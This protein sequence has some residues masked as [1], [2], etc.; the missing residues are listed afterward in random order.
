MRASDPTT[1][2]PVVRQMP[3]P[4]LPPPPAMRPSTPDAMPMVPPPAPSQPSHPSGGA[5]PAAAWFQQPPE[6]PRRVEHEARAVLDGVAGASNAA[7][8]P[9]PDGGPVRRAVRSSIDRPRVTSNDV[10]DLVWFEEDL[11]SRIRRYDPWSDA[12]R[13]DVRMDDWITAEEPTEKQKAELRRFV[14]RALGRVPTTEPALLNRLLAESVDEEGVIDRPLVVAAG[15]LSLQLDPIEVLKSS[16]EIAS[17]LGTSDKLKEAIDASKDIAKA[18]RVSTPLVES[19][20]ARLRKE[21]V[22]ANRSLPNDYL[23]STVQRTMLEER[24][25]QRREVL[26]QAHL[27]GMLAAPGGSTATYLPDH[28]ASH[29]P[30]FPRFKVRIVAEPHPAQHPSDGDAATLR[31]LALGRVIGTRAR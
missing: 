10:V 12:V 26:G 18:Q 5:Q 24:K 23:E 19:L 17:Q 7:A 2:P 9:E 22:Q 15:E 3:V 27:A 21:F 28:L 29:I 13:D 4:P 20:L 14:T 30:V 25:Y 8:R 16:V 1:P 11:P 31:V 6:P